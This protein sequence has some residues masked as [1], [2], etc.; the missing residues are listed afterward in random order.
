[1]G[2][3]CSF[4]FAACVDVEYSIHCS[5]DQ[6]SKQIGEKVPA[7]PVLTNDLTQFQLDQ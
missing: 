7:L 5:T 3:G 1:V 6:R 4:F 2:L